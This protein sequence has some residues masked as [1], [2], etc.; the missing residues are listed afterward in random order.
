MRILVLTNMY[1]PHHYGGYELSC[2]DVVEKWRARGH[3]VHVLTSDLQ[4]ED[5]AEADDEHGVSRELA[6]A[7]AAGD[8]VGRPVLRRLAVERTNQAML[9]KALVAVRPDVVSVWHMGAMSFSLLTTLIEENH[10]VA[11]VVCDD[12]LSYGPRVD[13]WM[14]MFVSRPRRARLVEWIAGVPCHLPDLGRSGPFCFVSDVTRRRSSEL[15]TWE[16]PVA[17]V[18]G[19]GVDTDL[20][21]PAEDR[22]AP[23]TWRVLHVG[24]LDP[25]K[26]IETAVRSLAVLPA[27]ATLEILGRGD[28][29][30]R[31]RLVDVARNLGVA[32]RVSF[33]SV[34]RAELVDRYRRADV[35]VF[36][37]EW[38]EPFGL[39]PL[40]A[41]AC[42]TPVVASGT[43]GSGEFLDGDKNCLLVPPANPEALAS[44][45][46]RLAADPVLRSAIV[47]GGLRTSEAWS[48]DRLAD[49]LEE[50]HVAAA[51]DGSAV[52]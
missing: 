25:R 39:V 2:R 45:I 7:F 42:G 1:P 15:S 3:V 31:D 43:G 14:R 23:W 32:D 33:G 20:F 49:I 37:A 19:S 27:Q 11:F 47:A 24:R 13:P 51:G 30:Y 50:W 41:M 5:P 17:T 29:R 44:A 26:G 40:E 4:V 21:S 16:F 34:G 48:V 28:D 6:I 36:P 12:W 8:L 10:P 38:E 18:T 9:R 46:R 35:V 22:S 52:Q